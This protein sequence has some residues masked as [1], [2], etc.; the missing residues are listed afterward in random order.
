M[1]RHRT[2]HFVLTNS[3]I[4][5]VSL[6]LISR[7]I[8]VTLLLVRVQVVATN[9]QRVARLGQSLSA[10]YS[11]RHMGCLLP[12]TLN[13]PLVP[14]PGGQPMKLLETEYSGKTNPQKP[15]AAVDHTVLHLQST[16]NPPT[17]GQ[18]SA[19]TPRCGPQPP[20]PA[21]PLPNPPPHTHSSQLHA[22]GKLLKGLLV[23]FP[24]LCNDFIQC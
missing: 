4:S 24:T 12:A 10:G 5:F 11:G 1:P 23:P 21:S 3:S 17:R 20:N 14:D 13:S 9:L 8:A 2:S 22:H 19:C 15:S 6:H 16:L 7:S 18:S